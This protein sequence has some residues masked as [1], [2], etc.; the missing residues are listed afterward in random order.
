MKK[1]RPKV[2]AWSDTFDWS[3]IKEEHLVAYRKAVEM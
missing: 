3:V 2:R 1:L